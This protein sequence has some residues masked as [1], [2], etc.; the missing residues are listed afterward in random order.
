MYPNTFKSIPKREVEQNYEKIHTSEC[1]TREMTPEEYEK[2]FGKKEENNLAKEPKVSREKLIELCKDYGTDWQAA[3]KIAE[4]TGLKPQT[5]STYIKRW[6]IKEDLGQL[7]EP[8]QVDTLEV[9]KAGNE[10]TQQ[11]SESKSIE[12]ET[13]EKG[14]V[15]K[16]TYSEYKVGE[17]VLGISF[18]EEL[19]TIEY[20]DGITFE[21]A[22]TVASFLGELL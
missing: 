9:I 16:I 19:I 2:Y 14:K 7:L 18:E 1:V 8:E 4:I 22:L 21:E 10:E 17:I 13:P 15:P 5:V 12:L 6:G 3:K 20:K 11:N